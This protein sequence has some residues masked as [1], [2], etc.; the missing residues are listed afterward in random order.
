[1][2]SRGGQA[3]E[4]GSVFRRGV[5]TSLAVRGLLGREVPGLDLGGGIHP[6]GLAFETDDATD[7]IMCRMSTGAVVFISAKRTAGNDRAFRD[8]VASWVEQA[9]RMNDGDLLVLATSELRGDIKQLPEMLERRR[10]ELSGS[11]AGER[12]A[13]QALDALLA[14]VDRG[15]RQQVLDAARVLLVPASA[16]GRLD[17]EQ[18]VGQLEGTLVRFGEGKHAL[19]LLSTAFHD[20]A[21]AA[22][23]SELNDWVRTLRDGGIEVFPDLKG[24]LGAKIAARHQSLETF[25]RV[26]RD[27]MGALNLSLLAEDLP[28]L[29]VSGMLDSIVVGFDG[30]RSPKASLLHVVRRWGRLVLFGLPGAGK[31]VALRE[32]AGTL[33][34]HQDAPTPVPVALRHLADRDAEQPLALHDLLAG[35]VERVPPDQRP[36]LAE[37]LSE[38]AG[39]GEV[40]FLCDGLDECGDRAGWVSDQVK[41]ILSSLPESTGLVLATR[42]SAALAARKLDV[43]AATLETPANLESTLTLILQTCAE[44]RVHAND[45][46]AWIAVRKKWIQDARDDHNAL[47]AVPLLAVLLTLIAADADDDDLPKERAKLLHRAVE[48]SVRKWED[49]RKITGRPRRGEKLPTRKMLLDGYT[50]LGTLIGAATSPSREDASTA[51]TNLF[52]GDRWRQAPADAEDA[53]ENVLS[54]W[55][56]HVGVFVIH[57]DGI[58]VSRSKVFVEV[59]EAM[60]TLRMPPERLTSWIEDHLE[61]IESEGALKLALGLNSAAA[62]ALLYI[63]RRPEHPNASIILADEALDGELELTPQQLDE[64]VGQLTFHAQAAIGGRTI[65]APRRRS[66]R[67]ADRLL[68]RFSGQEAVRSPAW[69]YI[70]R[71]CQLR[72][73]SQGAAFDIRASA[74]VSAQLPSDLET[75][76]TALVAVVQCQDENRCLGPTEL[77]GVQAALDLPIPRSP[78]LIRENRRRVRI[79]GGEPII[80]GLPELARHSIRFLPQLEERFVE[81]IYEIGLRSIGSQ[82]GWILE[83]LIRAGVDIPRWEGEFKLEEPLAKMMETFESDKRTLLEDIAAI[84]GTPLELNGD[85]RWSLSALG[86]LVAASGYRNAL[87]RDVQD[88]LRRD[89]SD[90]R[91]RWLQILAR[92][93]GIDAPFAASQAHQVLAESDVRNLW[94][95]VSIRPAKEIAL[96]AYLQLTQS[97]YDT[98]I[99]CMQARSSWIAW[100]AA[101]ILANAS[102]PAASQRLLALLPAGSQPRD[103]LIAMIAAIVAEAPDDVAEALAS[104]PEAAYRAGAADSL[105][106]REVSEGVGYQTLLRLAADDD[107]TVRSAALRKGAGR[108]I[109]DPET[110]AVYWSCR[111]CGY[112]NQLTERECANCQHGAIPEFE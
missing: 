94:G 90:L 100:S 81:K 42:S 74:I 104:A 102:F 91:R 108:R 58:L 98:L 92:M 12:K 47:L 48:D 111:W 112:F 41:K 7:D 35:A 28:T 49:Q 59:A 2:R 103:R 77:S 44:R 19:D 39:K 57:V 10:K 110:P 21:A 26:L 105:N 80:A 29:N 51:L 8:T 86:D 36:A 85:G 23:G 22:S 45:R 93:Y 11:S 31:S 5:A 70:R 27:P 3:N 6:S 87:A 50:T 9:R 1:M 25:L 73:P 71:L 66:S 69:P 65:P 97:E 106:L 109:A 30:E 20:Q 15:I 75:I 99:D 24:P 64:L 43:P 4:A 60:A 83:D 16:A 95:L 18:F 68:D 13:Q 107:L 88:A 37:V 53:A 55:D 52:A 67:K 62:E 54:F 61:Y 14:D 72:L 76:A 63:G 84:G 56:E 33:A 101:K 78:D 34:Q 89:T 96:H 46:T 38:L 17:Y 82:G 32:L 40:A 79:D